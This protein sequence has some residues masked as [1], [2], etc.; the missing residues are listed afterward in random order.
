MCG[1][2]HRT[3]T[4]ASTRCDCSSDPQD[5]AF[6]TENGSKVRVVEYETSEFWESVARTIHDKADL[7]EVDT[8]GV[9]EDAE[10]SRSSAG[11]RADVTG[12]P[13]ETLS[14]LVT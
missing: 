12:A 5:P 3:S 4:K 11:K 8:F 9:T 1:N 6:S 7:H 2:W 14:A 10:D 13:E